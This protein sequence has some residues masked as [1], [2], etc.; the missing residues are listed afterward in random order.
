MSKAFTQPGRISA[1]LI[2]EME[3]VSK[4]D[5]VLSGGNFVSGEVLGLSADG[6]KYVKLDLDDTAEFGA[7]AK[8]VLFGSVDATEEDKNGM[9]HARV[10]A[11]RADKLV[12]PDD[13]TDVRKA[14]FIAELV[15]LNIIPR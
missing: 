5:I 11:V 10:C 1:H 8:A 13:I 9:A 12:W 7:E 4:D 6:T 14:E 2:S 15:A 3:G